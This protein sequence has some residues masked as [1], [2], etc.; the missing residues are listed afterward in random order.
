MTTENEKRYRI[1]SLDGGGIRGV[2]SARILQE[3]EK[4]LEKKG[5]KLHT[6]FD[7]VAGTSTGSILAGAIACHKSAE[8][9]INLYNDEG[10]NIFLPSVRRQRKWRQISKLA[11]N[12]I[13]QFFTRF[14]GTNVLYP[15]EKG[16]NGLA[17]VLER[18]LGPTKLREIQEPRIVIPAY[19]V[20]NRNTTWF[21]NN[22]PDDAS[23]W[24]DNIELWKICTASASA[25]TYFPP[26]NLPFNTEQY[27]PHIDGGVSAN[28]PSLIALAR[29]LELDPELNLSK[30]AVLSIGTGNTTSPYT[31]QDIKRWGA[32]NWAQNIPSIFMDPSAIN[33]E[34]ICRRMVRI[35]GGSYLRLGFNLNEQFKKRE[36][37]DRIKELLDEDPYNKYILKDKNMK[38]PVSEEMDDPT[39]CPELIGA[40]ESYLKT[41]TVYEYKEGKD[42]FTTIPEAIEQFIDSNPKPILDSNSNPN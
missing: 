34:E 30:M 20:Y 26:Y 23:Q 41:A 21:S 24:Y 42:I 10:K 32:L 3:V 25:P 12:S 29:A 16:E 2:V 13:R 39:K 14:L 35:E 18:K 36:Q 27:L 5:H 38:V 6:Y 11:G 9:I 4:I 1:L 8:E 31:Y 19:D 40:A 37:Y 28:N 7:L 17:K 22:P 33:S 15:H